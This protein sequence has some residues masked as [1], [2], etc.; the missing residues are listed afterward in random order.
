M[1]KDQIIFLSIFILTFIYSCKIEN[2]SEPQEEAIWLLGWRMI[3]NARNQNF[4][5]AET[6]FDS[7]L[8]QDKPI[9]DVFLLNGLK[10][11]LK[12]SK[13]AEV[14]DIV[15][16]QSPIIRTKLCEQNFAKDLAICANQPLE[17]IENKAL[18]SEIIKLYIADQAI[19]RKNIL[20]DII[21]K[22]KIDTTGLKTEY[23]YSNPDEIN[24]DEIN[25]NR[26]K[27]IIKEFG[28]PTRKLVGKDAMH[29]VFL[30]I[31][32]ADGD[33]V[34][35]KLQLPY[36]KLASENGSLRKKDYAYLYDRT[37]V[38]RGLLQRYGTQ[39]AKVDPENQ[40]V[41]LRPTE[42]LLNLNNRRRAMDMMPI[43]VYKRGILRRLSE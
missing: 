34:W 3:E 24:V 10:L 38:N 13:E 16:N 9:G 32:H 21:E 8:T 30:I 28:F 14:I 39:F 12:L 43:E 19:R 29:G 25:R 26:L 11:K 1:K 37:Q 4:H 35:Q 40:V 7:L 31:Q 6:Q 5:L 15:S 42:D 36:M 23:D 18:Q 17:R 22:Y 2:Q 41:E 20:H 27:E 33:S